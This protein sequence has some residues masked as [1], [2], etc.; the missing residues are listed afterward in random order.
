MN[1]PRA[2][3]LGALAALA[4][5]VVL[6]ARQ[7][8]VQNGSMESGQGAGA[9]DPHVPDQWTT[10][11]LNVERSDQYNFTP[12]GAGHSLK[13]FGDGSNTVAGAYQLVSNVA[14]GQS[15]VASVQ[16]FTPGNDKLS[17]SGQA[18]L[19]FEFVNQFGGTIQSFEVFPLNASSPGDTWIPASL[20][21]FT[22]PANT[23]KVRVTC[24]L[25]WTPNQVS[26]AAY[27]DGAQGQINGGSNQ[28]LNGDFET[29]GHSTG[30]SPNG[31]DQWTGFNDQ[32]KSGDV[33][34]D[35]QYSLKVGM[36]EAYNGLYQNM[37][38]L[39]DGDH[40]VLRAFGW[41][42]A[43]DPLTANSRAGIK[44]EFAVNGN[45]PPPTQ[46]LTFDA[47]A[48]VDTWVRVDVTA[49]VP[50]LATIARVD[51]IFVGDS[52]TTGAVYFDDAW[53]EL[54]SQPGVNQLQND[55]F[56]SGP[57]GLNGLDNWT[58][59]NGGGTSQCEKSCFVVPAHSG[60][61]TARG[62][63]QTVSGVYQQFAAT[64]GDTV[65]F[66]A[67]LYTPDF[68]QLTGTG[69]AGVK[70]EWVV[71]SVPP[72]IDLGDPNNTLYPGAPTNTWLPLTIDFT[73]PPGSNAI[74]RFVD[75]TDRSAALSGHLYFDA[76]EAVVINKFD[77]LDWNGDNAEDMLDFVQLQYVFGVQ[78]LRWGGLTFDSNDDG[79]VNW[80]DYQYFAPRMRGPNP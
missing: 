78:P 72:N 56:E 40:I 38:A 19:V 17:G 37:P 44:L 76:C 77:G 52:T 68:E 16:L 20:G 50:A 67:W 34:M 32:Q 54:G 27:W 10:F 21:P 66:H 4:A 31:I 14:A 29:A 39:Q 12:P 47:N 33:A 41:N 26:G 58:E 9:I 2:A 23:A 46:V 35:G 60:I 70:I 5:P 30:Q 28:L 59:F 8:I 74:T 42:P 79:Q 36:R 80:P 64:T 61:C 11:G 25:L 3:A 53:A 48:Q 1:L 75:L 22:A 71:G 62:T 6:L 51:C 24:E 18:G 63:G 73:M 13:A 49:T 43:S 69:V 45:V 15:V 55:S 57:G 65:S 7:N